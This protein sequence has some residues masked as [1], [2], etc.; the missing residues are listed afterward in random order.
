VCKNVRVCVCVR[1]FVCVG[2][3]LC[4]VVSVYVCVCVRGQATSNA[5]IQSERKR[6]GTCH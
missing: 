3:W 2:V 4:V 1:V 5:M 6:E